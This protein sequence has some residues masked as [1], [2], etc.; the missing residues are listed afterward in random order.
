MGAIGSDKFGT[1]MKNQ[2]QKDGVKTCFMVNEKVNTGTCAVAVVNKERGLVANLAAANTYQK[3]HLDANNAMLLRAGIV[4]SAGFFVTVSPD[5]MLHAAETAHKTGGV[6][7]LNLAA[8]FVLQVPAFKENMMKLIG[9]SDYVF[10][11]ET[12][13]KVFAEQV[14]C[15]SDA[16]SVARHIAG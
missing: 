1:L 13:A 12:E 11:N 14:K 15:T 5:S 4:Y 3:S 9:F 7:C 10:G 8:P 16:S 2:C 6:Y